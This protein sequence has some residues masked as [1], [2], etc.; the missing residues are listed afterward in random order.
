MDV[1]MI[2]GPYGVFEVLLN[3]EPVIGVGALSAIG[4]LPSDKKI[5]EAVRTR[6]QGGTP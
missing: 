5:L 3:G 2:H 4:I 6:I 1:E